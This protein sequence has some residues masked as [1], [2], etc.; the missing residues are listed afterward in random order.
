MKTVFWDVDTQVDFIHPHGKLYV[1][2]AEKICTNLSQLTEYARKTG[3]IVA[4]VDYHDLSDPE[5][6]DDPDFEQTFPPHCLIDTP[7]QLKVDET[8]PLDPLWV[9]TDAI[10]EREIQEQL[11]THRGEIVIRK[12]R[13]DVFS[14]PNIDTVIAELAPDEIVLYGVAL[15]VCNRFAIEGL[16]ERN[17]TPISLVLDA[18]RAI[19]PDRGETLVK[20]WQVRD[21]RV[22]STSDVVSGRVGIES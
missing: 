2:G 14:N 21:V 22:V 9:D 16:L 1:N 18:T 17:V 13:F 11:S 6:S 4:S 3:R 15:D 8:V 20:S 10:P 12:K 5:I 7:G 19:D